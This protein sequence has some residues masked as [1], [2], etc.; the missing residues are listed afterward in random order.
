MSNTRERDN[1]TAA[2]TVDGT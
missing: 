2:S 1:Q